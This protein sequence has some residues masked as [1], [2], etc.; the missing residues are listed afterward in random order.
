MISPVHAPQLPTSSLSYNACISGCF[1]H[2][3]HEEFLSHEVR[4]G[5]GGKVAASWQDLHRAVVDFLVAAEGFMD[6]LSR[7]CESRRI[8]DDVVEVMVVFLIEFD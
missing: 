2:H 6:G 5:A 1:L 4:A 8:E 7:L 3:F